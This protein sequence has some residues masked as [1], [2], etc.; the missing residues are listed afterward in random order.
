MPPED[1]ATLRALP[2]DGNSTKPMASG[3]EQ[4]LSETS[5]LPCSVRAVLRH[6]HRQ[7]REI[8]RLGAVGILALSEP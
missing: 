7:A 5:L 8:K 3:S 4:T 6:S 1:I 2:M